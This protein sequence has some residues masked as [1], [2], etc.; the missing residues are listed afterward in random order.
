MLKCGPKC[1]HFALSPYFPPHPFRS[2]YGIGLGGV[3]AGAKVSAY[4][5]GTVGVSHTGCEVGQGIHTKVAQTVA[6]ALGIPLSSV[7]VGATAT[8]VFPNGPATGGSTTSETCCGA[9]LDACKALNDQLAPVK[10]KNPTLAWE[11][12]VQAGMGAGL[13]LV[14]LG[15]FGDPPPA[16]VSESFTYSTYGVAVSE[17]EIDVLT[18]QPEL[19]RTD[20]LLDLGRSINPDVDIGAWITAAPACGI[21]F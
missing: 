8:D 21:A 12:L 19:L 10:A 14:A 11:A 7:V 6:Y 18:G 5:D 3:T 1:S 4:S 20:L 2:R 9:A 17:V 15:W 16:D 13:S